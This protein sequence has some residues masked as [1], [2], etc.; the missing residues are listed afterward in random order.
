MTR[1]SAHQGLPS[2]EPRFPSSREGRRPGKAQRLGLFVAFAVCEGVGVECGTASSDYI[3]RYDGT[4]ETLR[5]S[6]ERIQRVASVLLGY[7]IRDEDS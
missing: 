4:P 5:A 6:L 7:L 2:G 3:S 1:A